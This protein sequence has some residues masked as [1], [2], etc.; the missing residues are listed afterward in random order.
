MANRSAQ[1]VRVTELDGAIQSAAHHVG[2]RSIVGW[3]PI[4]IGLILRSNG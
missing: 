4:I 2:T 1:R 3:I